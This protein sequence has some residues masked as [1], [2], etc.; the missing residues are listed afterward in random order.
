MPGT[1]P[2]VTNVISN[3]HLNPAGFSPI[4]IPHSFSHGFAQHIFEGLLDVLGAEDKV[5]NSPQN[6]K[7][8]ISTNSRCGKNSSKYI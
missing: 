5:V 1:V 8:L 3:P 2:G 7:I 4:L 6:V